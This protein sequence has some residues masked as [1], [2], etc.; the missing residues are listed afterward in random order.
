MI[1]LRP[2][3]RGCI[4]L[5]TLSPRGIDVNNDGIW[6]AL[7]AS[8]VVSAYP[9]DQTLTLF[10]YIKWALIRTHYPL[11]NPVSVRRCPHELAEKLD[12]DKHEK[13]PQD[14]QFGAGYGSNVIQ[15]DS[16]A[17]RR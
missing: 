10:I 1:G 3:T 2:Q 7:L 13:V 9:T 8:S 4:P 5:T 12:V 15:E 6:V 14:H 16:I 17:G 11:P